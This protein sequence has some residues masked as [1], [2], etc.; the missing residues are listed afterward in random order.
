ML[1]RSDNNLMEMH[2]FFGHNLPTQFALV[3]GIYYI[4]LSTCSIVF[5]GILI[6]TILSHRNLRTTA[7]VFMISLS[8]SD[9]LIACLVIPQDALFLLY[10]VHAGGVAT[11]AFK[12]VLFFLFLPA[13]VINLLLLTIERCLKIVSP[14]WHTKIFT[15]LNNIIILGSSW[16]YVVLV[17]LF[18]IYF[19][20]FMGTIAVVVDSGTCWLQ[21]PL[22]Y[23]YFQL[24]GSFF[25]PSV[26]ILVLNVVIFC[27]AKQHFKVIFYQQAVVQV[28]NKSSDGSSSSIN[29]LNIVRNMK[30][31]KTITLLVS[32]FMVC[33]LTFLTCATINVQCNECLKRELVWISN[34]I[35][36]SSCFLNPI[37]YGLLNR[38]V[39]NALKRW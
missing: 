21:F 32:V 17:A 26:T 37:I 33:W 11:C 38:Q 4:L 10:G 36:Y 7:N 16:T 25:L 29:W 23:I 12:E 2:L 24:G 14:Y 8:V 15:K 39:R 3:V 6:K 22:F 28:N 35:N 30:A 18:P 20:D 34:G 13:S 9:M 31:A 1:N 5:N 27:I 19:A